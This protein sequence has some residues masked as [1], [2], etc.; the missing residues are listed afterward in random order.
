MYD[1]W[2]LT[3]AGDSYAF[4]PKNRAVQVAGFAF[5]G[6]GYRT[7]DTANPRAD[8]TAFGQDFVESGEIAIQL[9]INY[10]DSPLPAADRA[11]LAWAERMA[12]THAWRADNVRE[13]PGAMSELI[14]GGEFMIEGRSRRV[15][16]NDDAQNVGLIKGTAL[17]VPAGTGMYDVRGGSGG[18]N[19]HT[20]GLMPPQ[21]G[22]LKAPLKAPLTTSF[23]SSRARSFVVGGSDPVW[24]IVTI[25]GPLMT[26][27]QFELTGGWRMPLNRALGEFDVAVIDTR[28]G[29]RSMTL[30]GRAANVLRDDGVMLTDASIA[31]GPQEISLRGRSLEGTATATI[32]W[33]NRFGRN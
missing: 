33:L 29:H 32:E 27:A 4:G 10:T 20:I 18:W 23:E 6:D 7:D 26:E 3:S 5:A 30:N 9:V 31:P 21:H 13:R 16:W 24:P 14:V 28:P 25:R 17:F 12:F 11:R 2:V 22:G 1:D 19:T 15:T 8:G